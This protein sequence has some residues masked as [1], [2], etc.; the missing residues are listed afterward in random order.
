MKKD[1]F[2][3]TRNRPFYP[4]QAR[5]SPA[6]Q[7]GQTGRPETAFLFRG[8]SRVLGVGSGE[9]CVQIQPLDETVECQLGAGLNEGFTYTE[10]IDQHGQGRSLASYL[11]GRYTHT[12]EEAWRERIREGRVLVEGCPGG[13]EVILKRGQS[14]TWMRPPWEEPPVPMGYAVLFEDEDLV[15]VA[16]P[17]GLPTMPGGGFLEHC[18]LSLVR[19]RYPEVSPAHRL[20][21]GT[22]GVVLFARTSLAMRNISAAWREHQA[23]KIYRALV[24]GQPVQDFFTVTEPIGP[25]PH[26]LLGTVHAASAQGKPSTSHVRV[27]ERRDDASVVE[28]RIETGRP[29]QIRIHLATCGHP[30]VGDPLYV[31]GGSP[32]ENGTA[33]PGDKGYLLHALR[34]SLS[35]PRSGEVF[36]VECAPPPALRITPRP[37]AFG[38]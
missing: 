34:L 24:T 10:I 19:R 18:L 25:V 2:A 16:K 15:A 11:A 30:L 26:P 37:G 1:G 6:G 22:S 23:E 31:V 28:V 20:G 33:L 9:D 14:V 3:K 27:L 21:R 35:H 7:N 5:L 4:E 29:H 12:S 32:L 8:D 13:V 38:R 17:S 36:R